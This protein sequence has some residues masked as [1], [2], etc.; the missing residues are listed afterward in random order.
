MRKVNDRLIAAAMAVMELPYLS[1]V[2]ER[3][4]EMSQANAGYRHSP[5]TELL[6]G[7]DD[8]FRS[9]G[10]TRPIRKKNT[11]IAGCFDRLR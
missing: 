6:Y 3:Q 7:M 8:L 5:V 4:D 2:G 10:I 1:A 9:G 11:V